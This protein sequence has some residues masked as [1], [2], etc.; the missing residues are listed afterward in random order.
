MVWPRYTVYIYYVVMFGVL[1]GILKV[2]EGAIVSDFFICFWDPLSPFPAFIWGD[3]PSLIVTWYPDLVDISGKPALFWREP[4]EEWMGWGSRET[5]RRRG[6]GN[7]G[8]DVKY[9]RRINKKL[10]NKYM[11]IEQIKIYFKCLNIFLK[12]QGCHFQGQI[13]L[14]T[15][16][17]WKR[18]KYHMWGFSLNN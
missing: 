7:C 18:Y 3:V 9:E 2:G 8:H 13:K 5:G 14:R 10:V 12:G 17:R 4:E 15:Q 6:R 11:G 1:V 16:N